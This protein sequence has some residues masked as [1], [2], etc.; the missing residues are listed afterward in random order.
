M[1]DL[2][3]DV[4]VVEG[5]FRVLQMPDQL[6]PLAS[7]IIALNMVSTNQ[8]QPHLRLASNVYAEGSLR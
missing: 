6:R 3:L 1:F 4:I 8:E 7:R 2:P 5:D